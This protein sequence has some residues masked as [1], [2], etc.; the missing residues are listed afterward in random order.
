MKTSSLAFAFA[1]ALAFSTLVDAAPNKIAPDLLA[2]NPA[3]VMEAIVQYKVAPSTAKVDAVLALGGKVNIQFKVIHALVVTL[4]VGSLEVLAKDPDIVYI[5]PDRLV[6][7]ALD[8]AEPTIGALTAFDN[9]YDGTGIGIAII[10]S[11]VT[12]HPDLHDFHGRSRVVFSLDLTWSGNQNDAYGHGDHV[13]GI[14]AGN[15]S[16]SV[17]WLYNH[18]FRGIAPN[19]NLINLKVLDKNGAGTD[20]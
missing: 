20:S 4:P 19:A 3:T 17:G 8:Y 10:D 7:K 1:V 18:T 14:L 11:G 15:A 12:D 13:A 6:K 5:S 16:E 2:M 9:H